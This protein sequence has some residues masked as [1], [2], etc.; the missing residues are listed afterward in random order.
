V[1]ELEN[2]F[3]NGVFRQELKLVR[4]AN[5]EIPKDQSTKTKNTEEAMG[6]SDAISN[7]A[8]TGGYSA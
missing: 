5:Q 2:I 8:A 7:N 4:V 6:M 3:E 1:S